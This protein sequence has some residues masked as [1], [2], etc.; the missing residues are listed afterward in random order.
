MRD[1]TKAIVFVHITHHNIADGTN[2]STKS[3]RIHPV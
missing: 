2:N 3:T 1:D